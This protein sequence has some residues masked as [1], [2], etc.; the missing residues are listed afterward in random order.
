MRDSPQ[1]SNLNHW[2]DDFHNARGICARKGHWWVKGSDCCKRCKLPQEL[3]SP[4]ERDIYNRVCGS[5]D[6]LPANGDVV[7]RMPLR[8]AKER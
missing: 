7:Q 6:E 2:R 4:S 1:T 3:A 8:V 5:V